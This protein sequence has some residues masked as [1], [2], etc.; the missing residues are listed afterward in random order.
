MYVFLAKY[1]VRNHSP[2]LTLRL[3]RNLYRLAFSVLASPV[4]EPPTM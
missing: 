1:I 3:L 2:R 4:L